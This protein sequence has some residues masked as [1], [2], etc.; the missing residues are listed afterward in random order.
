MT[1]KLKFNSQLKPG[2]VAV[3]H[4]V[5]V[6]GFILKLKQSQTAYTHRFIPTKD[7]LSDFSPT[8]QGYA[9]VKA[10]VIKRFEAKNA[11]QSS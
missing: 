7:Y 8:G 9:A 2:M 10:E 6:L 11:K 1:T 5:E 4:G 3:M